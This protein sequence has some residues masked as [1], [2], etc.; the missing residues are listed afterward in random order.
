MVMN[1]PPLDDDKP[2]DEVIALAEERLAARA[3][4]NW[5]EFD[6]LR[7]EITKLGW[8]IQDSKEGYNLARN[9]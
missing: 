6:K 1:A 5:A 7:D 8:T 9:S 3:N 4:K 2:S